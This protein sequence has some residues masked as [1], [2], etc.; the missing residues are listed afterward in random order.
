MVLRALWKPPNILPLNSVP[1]LVPDLWYRTE[2]V[3][4]GMTIN[5]MY[6]K[7]ISN[8]QHDWMFWFGRGKSPRVHII[9][10]TIGNYQLLR[11]ERLVFSR[12]E[13][14]HSLSDRKCSALK[15]Y[16]TM[17]KG[18]VCVHACARVCTRVHVTMINKEEETVHVKGSKGGMR[19]GKG[20]DGERLEK[21]RKMM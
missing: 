8:M 18:Y 3:R 2:H 12:D 13:P 6:L 14:P 5:L 1:S 17:Q 16:T 10:R 7:K 21:K 9:Q 15:S 11:E 19:G 4:S 20:K